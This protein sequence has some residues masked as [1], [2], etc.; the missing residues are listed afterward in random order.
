MIA[1]WTPLPSG[2]LGSA[3]ANYIAA[4]FPSAPLSNTWYPA[5]LANA[6]AGFDLSVP[7]HD[8]NANFNSTFPNWYFERTVSLLADSMI[9]FL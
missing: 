1:N 8:I 5:A 2:V 6:L 9:L 4:N 7:D 3:G